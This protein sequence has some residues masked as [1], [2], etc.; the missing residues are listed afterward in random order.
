MCAA[1]FQAPGRPALK[2]TKEGPNCF[3]GRLHFLHSGARQ[4]PKEWCARVMEIPTASLFPIPSFSALQD[5][6]G[7]SAQGYLGG[8][9]R[10]R[11]GE[12]SWHLLGL[13][14]WVG[15]L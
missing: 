12:S 9:S 3:P 13:S 2:K 11:G 7:Y 8:G 6:R 4:P 5:H 14:S 10:E 15:I 1:G